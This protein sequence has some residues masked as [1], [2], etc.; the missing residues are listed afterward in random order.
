MAMNVFNSAGTAFLGPQA[1]AFDRAKMLAGAPATFVTPGITGRSERAFLP[2]QR[3]RRFAFFQPSGTGNPFVS[4]PGSGTYKVRLFHADFAT[5]DNT[6]FTLIGS[7]P[8]A[9]FTPLCP[10][11]PSLCA[12]TG[13]RPLTWM[14]SAT[15]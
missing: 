14:A 2:A 12:S 6:T 3:P 15:V 10:R 5:P 7:P 9:G 11:D 13:H 4:F 1:F 8:A